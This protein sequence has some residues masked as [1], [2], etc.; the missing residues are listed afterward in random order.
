ML[1]ADS[2]DADAWF[3]LAEIQFHWGPMFGTPSTH[4]ARAWDRVLDLDPGNAGALIHRLRIA[5]LQFD[6][7]KFD[8]L[9]AR[10]DRLAPSPDRELEIRGLRAFAFGDGAAQASAARDV[11]ALD[12]LKKS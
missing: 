1:A 4:S 12:V 2:T 5:A 7:A 6:R 8:A 10:L 9:A 11:A 3:S